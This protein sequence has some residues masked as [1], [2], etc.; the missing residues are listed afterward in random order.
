MN[1]LRENW[2]VILR[3]PVLVGVALFLFG[4]FAFLRSFPSPTTPLTTTDFALPTATTQ[5]E[6]IELTLF[7]SDTVER[8]VRVSLELSSDPSQ[9]YTAILTALRDALQNGD[10][11]QDAER[12]NV[13][14][15]GLPLPD[16][17]LLETSGNRDLTLHFT[18]DQPI[19]VS[20]M[21]EV[22]LYNSIV[23]TLTRNGASQVHLLVNDNAETFLGHIAL[24]NSLSE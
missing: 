17:F 16:I 9:R 6:E 23:T 4:L 5:S 12:P 14:P 7:E 19:P 21:T 1:W 20:V 8:P 2:R 24:E 3:V 18:F 22:R 11:A 13:W 15:R 10:P